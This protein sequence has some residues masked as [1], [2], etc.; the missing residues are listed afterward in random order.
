MI[1]QYEEHGFIVTAAILPESCTSCPFWGIDM[2][3]FKKGGCMITGTQI[4]L[5]GQQDEKRM[6]D[7]PIHKRPEGIPAMAEQW[8]GQTKKSSDKKEVQHEF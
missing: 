2:R 4:S 3:S 8:A 6:D 7:C 1:A 5:D